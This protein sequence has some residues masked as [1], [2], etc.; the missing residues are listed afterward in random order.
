MG[1]VDMS[2]IND[3]FEEPTRHYLFEER[4]PRLVEERRPAGFFMAPSTRNHTTPMA[5]EKLIKYDDQPALAP[6]N[7]IRR[8]VNEW[9]RV[10]YPRTTRITQ[11]LLRHWND[12]TRERRLFFCQR[13]A[14]ETIIWLVE[15]PTAEKQGII[16]PQ[17]EPTG[18]ESLKK[19]YGAVRRYC[20]KM[21]TG[22]GSGDRKEIPQ[23]EAWGQV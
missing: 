10:G 16:I 13:E 4:Q 8:R 20:T 5:V 6:V 15:A 23:R 22:I 1:V 11:E 9:R 14:A 18:P 12:P 2:I 3:P 7:E 19:E 17:D 21:A